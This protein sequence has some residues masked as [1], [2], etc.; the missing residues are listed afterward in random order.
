[1]AERAVSQF[2]DDIL[3]RMAHLF[4]LVTCRVPDSGE[5]D[6]LVTVYQE[7]H[8]YFAA[9]PGRAED[10]VK[11]GE[12]PSAKELAPTDVAATAMVNSLLFNLDEGVRKQ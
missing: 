7:Q 9:H 6:L 8:D 12:F 10:F 4:R 5:L 2:P 11:V 3:A 1:M